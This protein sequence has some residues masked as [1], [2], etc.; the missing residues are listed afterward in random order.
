MIG[1]ISGTLLASQPPVLLID[2]GGLGYEVEAPMSVFYDLP[3][4]GQAIVMLTHLQVSQDHQT[5][6]GF[7][8]SSQRTL[9]RQLM[10][11]P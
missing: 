5:L 8:S 3:E 4:I 7:R 2:V 9:F 1:R 10:N 11:F 6:Y